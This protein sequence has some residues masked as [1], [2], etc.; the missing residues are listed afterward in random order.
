MRVGVVKQ[1]R[2]DRQE[3]DGVFPLRL[4]QQARQEAFISAL[5]GL[6]SWEVFLVER[7][8]RHGRI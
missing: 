3:A 8:R 1:A 7:R 2:T 6:E 4:L 5:P